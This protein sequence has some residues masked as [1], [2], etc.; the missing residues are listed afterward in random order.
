MAKINFKG[1][2]YNKLNF[3]GGTDKQKLQGILPII[4]AL[5]NNFMFNQPTDIERLTGASSRP[6]L[7]PPVDAVLE[8][9]RD[10]NLKHPVM[11]KYGIH[12]TEFDNKA[13]MR[14]LR[15][16]KWRGIRPSTAFEYG[17]EAEKLEFLAWQNE[18]RKKTGAASTAVSTFFDNATLGLAK[19]AADWSTK[20]QLKHSDI[21]DYVG[22]LDTIL[23]SK[24]LAKAK[25]EHPIAA[26][27]GSVVGGAASLV[28]AQGLVNS[29]LLKMPKFVT[30]PFQTQRAISTAVTFGGI[31]GAKTALSEDW[32]KNIGKKTTD[33]IVNTV[34][35]GMA[36]YLGGN[37]SVAIGNAVLN[38]LAATGLSA[39]AVKGIAEA[40]G[41]LAFGVTST[42]LHESKNIALALARGEQ[43]KPNT[44]AIAINVSATSVWAR[45][46]QYLGNFN[47]TASYKFYQNIENY[48]HFNKDDFKN[49]NTLRVKRNELV[50]KY[51]TDQ[52]EGSHRTMAEINQE[53]MAAKAIVANNV[54]AKLQIEIAG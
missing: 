40:P 14:W 44:N 31:S 23:P 53:Y 29:A 15:D 22:K 46:N 38:R 50:F 24:Q 54:M 19:K 42:A 41:T 18:A 16:N 34:V 4:P 32:S 20:M 48:K 8:P 39:S 12:P 43:Y 17:K 52:A 2:D 49:I 26:L 21:G 10:V 25:A 6:K 27:G 37:A 35:G 5:T 51:H 28:L 7:P 3:W 47:Q 36:G 13:Y 1:V 30:L 9:R 11:T 45:L 33:T